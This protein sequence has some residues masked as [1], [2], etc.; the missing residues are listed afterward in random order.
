MVVIVERQASGVV[1]DSFVMSCRAMGYG[2]EQV[3][4]SHV[5]EAEGSDQD[6]VGLFRSTDRNDPASGLYQEA[7]FVQDEDA[8]D[9][10]KRARGEPI[11]LGNVWTNRT[12]CEIFARGAGP[13]RDPALALRA[14]A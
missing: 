14:A 4:L 9:R 2:V 12:R 8:A 5:M 3:T 7:G 1:L 11:A 10:W 13:G 6:F